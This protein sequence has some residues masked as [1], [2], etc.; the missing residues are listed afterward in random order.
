LIFKK[1]KGPEWWEAGDEGKGLHPL[2]PKG[3][4]GKGAH[5]HPFL[6]YT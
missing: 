1:K 6:L 3:K 2:R 4:G 5:S